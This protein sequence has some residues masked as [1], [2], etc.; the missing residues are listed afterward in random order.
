[1]QEFFQNLLEIDSQSHL[2]RTVRKPRN[3]TLMKPA[4]AKGPFP[5]L[6]SIL[7]S[8]LCILP[9]PAQDSPIAPYTTPQ[10]PLEELPPFVIVGSKENLKSQVGASAFLDTTDIRTQNYT[11]VNR[12]LQRVPGV[13][14]RDEDGF[15]N[16]ANISIRGGD[17]SRSERVTLMEDGVLTAPAPY[18]APG[19]YYTPRAARMSGIEVLKGSS[20]VR[21]GPHTTGGV[22]NFLST[23]VPEAQSGYLRYTFGSNATQLLL[24]QYGDVVT[25][26]AGT[27]GYLLEMHGQMSDG[28]RT[29]R[30]YEGRGTGFQLYEPMFKAFWEPATA[31]EQRIEFKF[32][33]TDFDADESYLGLS[34]VDARRT[35]RDRYPSTVF[36]NIDTDH[37]RTYLR[38]QGQPT[39]NL[40]LESTAY[41]NRFNRNWYKIDSVGGFNPAIDDT[42]Q[43]VG[44]TGLSSALLAGNPRLGV[45]QG[46]APGSIGVKSN[47]RTYES[48]GWQNMASLTFD[49]GDIGHTLNGGVRFH[50][51]YEDRLQ[52]MDVYNGDGNS[53]FTSYRRGA[54]GEEA[55]QRQE[56][57]ATSF[58]VEDAIQIGPVTVKPGVRYEKLQMDLNDRGLRLGGDLDTYA[59]GAGIN[60]NLNDAN[61]LFGGVFRGIS[62]PGPTAYLKNGI[63][64][65]ESVGYEAGIRHRREAFATEFA[66]FVTDYYNLLGTDTGLGLGGTSNLNAG[67]ATVWGFESMVSYDLMA[68]QGS[69]FQMPAYLTAT[70][71][72][73]ELENALSSG[74]K[75]NIYAGGTPGASIPY[76]P[77][78]KLAGGV[79]VRYDAFGLNLDGTWVDE[80][81]GTADNFTSPVTSVRQGIIDSALVF[82]LSASYQIGE[83][84][85]LLGGVQNLFDETYISSRLPEGP[86]NAAP[87]TVFI[88]VEMTWEALGKI[89]DAI[90]Q[91]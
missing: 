81:F 27:F 57:F 69:P 22:I 25:T 3:E 39:D 35:P 78:W 28:F 65:E 61:T 23:P 33:Y 55:D 10:G 4:R 19:A 62:T 6:L 48:Y 76:V 15:G 11:N 40:S 2:L 12:I 87:R 49:T 47:N 58:F 32:G 79:G 71:T 75:D 14:V 38:W 60:Y 53:G 37:I 74:G 50:A 64:V 5:P 36:D 13:Y 30:G 29:I 8:A 67:A 24:A 16:F 34:E 80:S 7:L 17:G 89:G 42:G 31:M 85:K 9:L 91:K 20:Q 63:N 73:A 82:D 86:R 44:R 54:P 84:T 46:T 26:D 66:G 77:Q 1:M 52:L 90:L 18:S 45:L 72:S 21:Y 56:V 43:I 51:D 88:G 59:A 83:H 68:S 70:W 41:F